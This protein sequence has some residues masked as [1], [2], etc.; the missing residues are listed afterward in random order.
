MEFTTLPPE[1]ISALIHSGPG[2][3]SLANAAAAWQQLSATLEDAADNYAATVSS[4]DESWYGP[5]STAMVEAAAPYLSWLRTTSQQ[6]QQT[7][8]AAQSAAAAANTVRASVVPTA[9]VVANRAR[10]A[11]LQATNL[12]GRNLPAIAQ[13]ES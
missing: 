6:T 8:V 4:L 1:V 2:S 12:L 9:T 5:S 7:A 13:T 11:Q 10:L 3:E